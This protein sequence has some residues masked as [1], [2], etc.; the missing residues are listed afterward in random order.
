MSVTPVAT[1][2]VRGPHHSLRRGVS[3]RFRIIALLA[4][5]AALL[6]YGVAHTGVTADEPNHVLG[7]H[8]YWHNSK[9]YPLPDLAPLLKIVSGWAPTA[10]GLEMPSARDPK[11]QAG[12]EWSLA[13]QWSGDLK[14]PYYSQLTWAARL[15]VLLFPLALA[16][17]VWNWG[18]ADWGPSAGLLAAAIIAVE[19]TLLGHG[20]LVKNDVACALGYTAF[21][22][23]AWRFWQAPTWT[24]VLW[25]SGA[26]VLGVSAKL[27][28]LILVGI[29][30]LLIV[31]RVPR[32]AWLYIPAFGVVFYAGLCLIHQGNVR[33]LDPNEVDAIYRHPHAPR[34][35]AWAASLFRWIPVP[36]NL[37][38]GCTSL[39]LAS[40]DA[41]PVYVWGRTYL[42]GVPWY[43]LAAL[44]VKVPIGFQALFVGAGAWAA[45]RGIRD[46]DPRWLF[47][48]VPPLLYIGLASLSTFQ[49]G[50]RLILPAL[51][52]GALLAAAAWSRWRRFV[53]LAAAAGAMEAMIY[54]PHGISFFNAW[55]GG[56]AQGLNYLVDSNLDWGQDLAL[57]KSWM[58]R[59]MVPQVRLTYFGAD[60]PWRYFPDERIIWDPPP[61]SQELA[62]GRTELALRPGVYAIS[63]SVMPGHYFEPQFR[64]FYRQFRGRTPTAMA[65]YSIYIYDL[66]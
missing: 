64:E 6:L 9:A 47:L 59:H 39:I 22:F 12:N 36:Q 26:T 41:P 37:W 11:W 4:V 55:V 19:P 15:P 45:W 63:A 21:W 58:D 20:V 3:H 27:S 1:P 17:L 35:L 32:R 46:R 56:P 7:A 50:I 25:L 24:R 34:L 60:A 54:Y 18:R 49:L 40:G 31:L 43:F 13:L 65:G 48:L 38:A 42:G 52:F 51:P 5:L 66:R 16:A 14:D 23:A 30:P 61:W 8:F 28:L 33:L 44:A 57:L 62:A 53:M 2:D 29:A 10:F